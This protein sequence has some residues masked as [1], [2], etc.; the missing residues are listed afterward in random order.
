MSPFDRLFSVMAKTW[1]STGFIAL[2]VLSFL[3][4]DKSIAIYFHQLDLEAFE[5]I[6]H[7]VT[8]LGIVELYV[9]GLFLLAL[10]FRYVYRKW[11]WEAY[12]WFLWLCVLIPN[13][14]CL[15]LKVGLGRA[16]PELWFEKQLYGFYGFHLKSSYWSFPSGHTTTMMGLM[17]GLSVLFPRGGYWFILLGLLA[18]IS[19]IILV[20]HY[21]SDV[22][23]AAYL[24]LV[25]IGVLVWWLRK[26]QKSRGNTR[27]NS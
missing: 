27:L 3:Y 16:R 14:I 13:V 11:K 18:S 1:V 21:L 12:S 22:L 19:R 26:N 24:A 7:G 6:L 15:F 23:I 10:F 2:L 5:L 8:S 20:K 25:E 9:V 17:L 4:L